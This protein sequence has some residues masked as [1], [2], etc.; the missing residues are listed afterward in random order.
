MVRL[1][2]TWT[3]PLKRPAMRTWPEPTILPSMVRSDA[4][5]DSF[6]SGRSLVLVR[7]AAGVGLRGATLLVAAAGR[8]GSRVNVS[9]AGGTGVCEGVVP[10]VSFQSA[11]VHLLAVKRERE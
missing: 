7:G 6:I 4:M 1:P 3:S 8:S 10:G 5:T 9:L 11:M 2:S